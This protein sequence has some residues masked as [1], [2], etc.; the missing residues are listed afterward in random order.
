[1]VAAVPEITTLFHREKE[2]E[3]GAEHNAAEKA[4]AV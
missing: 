2:E 3:E 4:W 1:M